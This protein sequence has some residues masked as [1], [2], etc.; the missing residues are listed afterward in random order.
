MVTV[1]VFLAVCASPV[2]LA[3]LILKIVRN[4]KV[5]RVLTSTIKWCAPKLMWAG[6]GVAALALVAFFLHGVY[7]LLVMGPLGVIIILLII[8]SFQL[9]NI[10]TRRS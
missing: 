8:I 2:L 10:N 3:L 9:S 4:E 6:V 7:R 1:I 5:D